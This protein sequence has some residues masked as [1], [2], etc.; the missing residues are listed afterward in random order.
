MFDVI[1]PKKSKCCEGR[2]SKTKDSSIT[3]KISEVLQFK[4]VKWNK[5]Y[6][7]ICL[8]YLINIIVMKY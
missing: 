7:T 1:T 5:K 6:N 8:N 4:F 3:Q 2:Y